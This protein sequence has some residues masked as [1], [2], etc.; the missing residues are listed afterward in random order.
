MA[1][2]EAAWRMPAEWEPH[3]ATWIAWPHEKSDWPGKFAPIPWVYAEIARLL[4]RF[5][6]LRVLV[7][8]DTARRGAESAFEKSGAN[9]DNIEFFVCPTNRSWLRDTA[10]TFVKNAVG[11]VQA[12]DWKFNAWAKYSNYALD[13]KVPAFIARRLGMKRISANVVLEGGGIDVN[14]HGMLLTTEEWLLSDTQV[15][16]PGFTRQ[17]YERV[18][19]EYLGVTEVVWLA[20][21]IPGDDTH[22]H[23]DDLARF[24]GDETVACLDYEDCMRRI[25]KAGL[26]AVKLPQPAP[27]YFDGQRL[28]ASYANFYIANGAVL[29]PTFNDPA[30]RE[31]LNILQ[32]CFPDREVVG[33]ACRDLVLG[34]GTLHCLTQQ[35][36]A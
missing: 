30:D 2:L 31:A 32:K 16:N 29:V 21:G 4:S 24:V 26:K 14:G 1:S 12:I 11:Q 13:D 5:E 27:V 7:E 20:N 36:P 34:L 15:R 9:L 3:E 8:G 33:V 6:K 22:G 28:P 35:Q 23:V 19:H 17:D 10:P 18:F 25:R